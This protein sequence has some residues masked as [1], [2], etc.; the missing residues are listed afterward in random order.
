MPLSR[1][2]DP[3]RNPSFLSDQVISFIVGLA[4][5]SS[6]LAKVRLTSLVIVIGLVLWEFY[7]FYFQ[8][9]DFMILSIFR[10]LSFYCIYGY[11]L[12]L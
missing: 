6:L 5:G 10:D 2:R 4:S 12:D 1:V 8:T 7:F 3:W 9:F 11:L